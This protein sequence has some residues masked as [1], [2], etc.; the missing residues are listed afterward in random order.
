MNIQNRYG[1]EKFY[2]HEGVLMT[3][4]PSLS[5]LRADRVAKCRTEEEITKVAAG[6]RVGG[7]F[8][9]A[10]EE[11]V[12]AAEKEA[13]TLFKKEQRR[14]RALR[15]RTGHTELE[16]RCDDVGYRVGRWAGTSLMGDSF[17]VVRRLPTI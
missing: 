12:N 14:A 4:K 17:R 5:K 15:K 6:W 16:Q 11:D 1:H 8:F 2:G 10:T 9:G 3:V 7:M 13:L